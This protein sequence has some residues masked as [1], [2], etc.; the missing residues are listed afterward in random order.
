MSKFLEKQMSESMKTY[1][2]QGGDRIGSE[3]EDP[4]TTD[5]KRPNPGTS[6]S[7]RHSTELSFHIHCQTQTEIDHVI[8]S[9]LFSIYI[10]QSLYGTLN[11]IESNTNFLNFIIISLIP[12]LDF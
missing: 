2:S 4:G 8:L 1:C 12:N 3:R 6:K 5:Q 7:T 10:L 11:F 9:H